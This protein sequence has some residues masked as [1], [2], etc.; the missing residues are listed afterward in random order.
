MNGLQFIIII[1]KHLIFN[2]NIIFNFYLQI[3]LKIDLK[4]IFELKDNN[5]I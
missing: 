3:Y 4:I 2:Y 1:E 5:I